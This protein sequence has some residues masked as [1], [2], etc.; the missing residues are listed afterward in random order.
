M[1]LAAI[2]IF[3]SIVAFAAVTQTV[4]GFAMGLIIVALSTALGIMTILEV[5]AIISIISLVNIVL[6]LRGSVARINKSLLG[7]IALG[8]VPGLMLGFIWLDEFAGV[9][10]AGLK[11]L[12]GIMV[13]TAGLSMMLRPAAWPRPSGGAVTVATGFLGGL[14]GG[15]YSAAG[16]PIAYLTYRQ[17]L[18]IQVI[19]STLLAVFFLST[20]LRAGIGTVYGHFTETVLLQTVL[21]LPLVMAI[22][23]ALKPALQRLPEAWVRRW[24]FLVLQTVGL[25]P[26]IQPL[27]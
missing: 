19:R 27:L 17:P 9:W 24:V 4:T 5:T 14:F 16:A 21:A 26:I 13:M 20:S 7:L 10:Q 18:E 1:D 12:L 6:V 22:S 8:L 23:I 3:L 25:W 2:I 15:L 11:M